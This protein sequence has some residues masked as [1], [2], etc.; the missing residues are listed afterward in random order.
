[1]YQLV[2]PEVGGRAIM[3]VEASTANI[4]PVVVAAILR[5][6]R[7]DQAVYK[8]FIDLQVPPST[9]PFDLLKKSPLQG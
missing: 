2:E 9:A 5:D 4:R 8:S 3:R 1:V 7:F 6:I